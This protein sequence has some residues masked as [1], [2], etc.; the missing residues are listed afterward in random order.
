MGGYTNLKIIMDDSIKT[1]ALLF[2]L[3]HV[4]KWGE[5]LFEVKI[6]NAI[7]IIIAN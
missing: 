5:F 3:C 2:L 7:L 4:V 6:K 1:Q